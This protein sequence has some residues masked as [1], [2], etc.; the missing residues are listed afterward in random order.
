MAFDVLEELVHRGHKVVGAL[1]EPGPFSDAIQRLGISVFPYFLPKLS[2]GKKS[3][4]DIA[5]LALSMPRS[6]A[7]LRR[8]FETNGCDRLFINGARGLLPASISLSHSNLVF[9]AHLIYQGQNQRLVTNSLLKFAS[10]SVV[11]PSRAVRES[12]SGVASEVIPNW[13]RD[14]F[15]AP[16]VAA[17]ATGLV[18]GIAGRI[19]KNKGHDLLIEALRP[20]LESGEVSLRVAGDSDFEDP[21]FAHDLR[22][23]APS[24][25]EFLG[26]V[27]D[28]AEFYDS[29]SILAVP[30]ETESFGLVAIEAMARARTVV[31]SRAGGL[32]E[33]IEDGCTGWLVERT[34]ASLRET[35]LSVDLKTQ[36]AIGAAAREYALSHFSRAG[37]LKQVADL[38]D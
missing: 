2:A 35:I 25:V 34:S 27:T 22:A 14:E 6:A 10:R 30:S 26:T 31:A 29:I 37:N 13:L 36:S 16:T 20:E 23:S 7:S 5:K 38:F 3:P 18:V 28:M 15:L 17:P 32:A 21:Q 33:M 1:P 12:L 19:S 4:L 24:G 11:S 8:I 9:Y